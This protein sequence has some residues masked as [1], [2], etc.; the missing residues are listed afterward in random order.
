[1]P[2]REKQMVLRHKMKEE[3]MSLAACVGG[4]VAR[5]PDP[6]RACLNNLVVADIVRMSV[7]TFALTFTAFCKR[8]SLFGTYHRCCTALRRP[9][10]ARCTRV[11]NLTRQIATLC[12]AATIAVGR[13]GLGGG[14]GRLGRHEFS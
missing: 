2:I 14:L 3:G 4:W 13:R 10:N 11:V 7:S 12:V 8:T 1:M 9:K 5:A 6:A